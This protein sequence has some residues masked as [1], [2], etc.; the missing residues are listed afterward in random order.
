MSV[1]PSPAS[2][3]PLV[4]TLWGPTSV[5]VPRDSWAIAVSSTRTSVPVGRVSMAGCAWTEPTGTLSP[6]RALTGQKL[7]DHLWW[8]WRSH[9]PSLRFSECFMLQVIQGCSSHALLKNASFEG[10]CLK[11]EHFPSHSCNSLE[12]LPLWKSASLPHRRNKGESTFPIHGRCEN[13][14]GVIL[15]VNVRL[16]VW[17]DKHIN[18]VVKKKSFRNFI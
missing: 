16:Y 14:A 5:T 13:K 2:M 18:Q 6:E 15:Y 12:F 9:I 10:P 7:L 17:N 4:R 11:R 1:G 3:V 8:I